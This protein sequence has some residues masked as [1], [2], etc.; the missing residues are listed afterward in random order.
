[1]AQSTD[2][3][4]SQ[5]GKALRTAVPSPSCKESGLD[6]RSVFVLFSYTRQSWSTACRKGPTVP[7][8][9]LVTNLNCHEYLLTVLHASPGLTGTHTVASVGLPKGKENREA[10]SLSHT[11]LQSECLPTAKVATATTLLEYWTGVSV[12]AWQP[13]WGTSALIQTLTLA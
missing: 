9:G 8:Q 7:Q 10:I 4:L 1:M 13:R 6:S 11:D 2:S 12:T 5:E 3:G